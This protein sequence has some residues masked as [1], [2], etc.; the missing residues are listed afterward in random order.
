VKKTVFGSLVALL[1]SVGMAIAQTAERPET[2]IN[3][4][5]CPY[6]IPGY[7]PGVVPADAHL[8][9]GLNGGSACP[10]CSGG[11]CPQDFLWL[12]AEY[13]AW[14]VKNGPVATPLATSG[15]SADL[16]PGALGQANTSVLLGDHI[17]YHGFSGGRWSAGFWASHDHVLG[18]EASGFLLET[19]AER[20]TVHSDLVGRPL[21][22]QPFFNDLTQAEDARIITQP[23]LFAGGVAL[24]STSHLWGV[25][26]NARSCVRQDGSMG[27]DVLAGFRYAELDERLS[28]G[29]LST[30]LAQTSMFLFD[31]VPFQGAG[32]VFASFDEFSTKNR[33]YGGQ[34]G[35]QAYYLWGGAFVS[36]L[37][38]VALGDNHE[39]VGISGFSSASGH[40]ALLALPSG[41]FAVSSN[42]GITQHDQ[43][44]VIPELR[45]RLGY[46]F[47]HFV[48]A[49][50]GY[51]FLY[52]SD[53][54][55]PGDQ[56]DRVVN[57][58]LI[59]TSPLFG[60]A[61]GESRPAARAESSDF[62]A[63]GLEI[64]IAVSY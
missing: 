62:W 30:S 59:A 28:I 14:W 16:V 1:S 23:G 54:V 6:G 63:Q 60:Q 24:D 52:W 18:F 46:Q 47:N 26:G 13:L 50:V 15:N 61:I 41:L 48:S 53:V 8:P 55:R 17:D 44:A 64:G 2:P 35:A 7:A 37:G 25:E 11:G 49:Y 34:I 12:E 43:F 10:G 27:L 51:T 4:V 36:A 9:G 39:F 29:A 21:I 5:V 38:K 56:I 40:G 3:P 32:N 57:P 19:R 42:R 33:F 45:L 22:A 20:L 31:N 58:T